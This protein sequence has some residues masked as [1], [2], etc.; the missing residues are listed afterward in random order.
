[1]SRSASASTLELAHLLAESYVLPGWR[2]PWSFVGSRGR[3]EWAWL[4]G[5][6]HMPARQ[7]VCLLQGRRVGTPCKACVGFVSGAQPADKP[8]K[9]EGVTPP[10][11]EDVTVVGSHVQLLGAFWLA[12]PCA[13]IVACLCRSCDVGQARPP[14][15]AIILPCAAHSSVPALCMQPALPL[16]NCL[17]RW[18]PPRRGGALPGPLRP[19]PPDFCHDGEDERV[20]PGWAP[21]LSARLSW[22]L[23]PGACSMLQVQLLPMVR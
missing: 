19:G 6:D 22:R 12:S 11:A 10:L 9:V 1:M 15:R 5:A 13:S 8:R 2:Q 4:A 17:P 16:P 21:S 14:L 20:L 18:L 7:S 3:R 23:D